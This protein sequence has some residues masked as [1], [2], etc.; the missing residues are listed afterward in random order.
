MIRRAQ[1]KDAARLAEI[2]I[3]AKRAAYRPIFQDDIVSFNEMQVLDLAL[4]FQNDPDALNGL[5]VY[6]DGILRGLLR[7]DDPVGASPSLQLKE[8]YVDPFFQG[9]GVGSK[10]MKYFL[11][12]VSSR[13]AKGAFL[14]VLEK[15]AKA[16]AFYESF[17]F[18]PE[19]ERKLQPGTP[20]F[21]LKYRYSS[22]S[23][24]SMASSISSNS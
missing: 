3:F 21:L 8:L 18:F 23:I 13:N 14:W 7:M 4:R 2:L 20:E 15:N 10:L 12:E 17:G 6:D 22:P 24:F 16:R 11:S 19:G 1:K 9:Q 5:F